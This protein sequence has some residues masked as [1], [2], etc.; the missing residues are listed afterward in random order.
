M[1]DSVGKLLERILLERLYEHLA[2][3]GGH[4]PN[5]Y[6]FRRGRSTEDAIGRVLETARWA[7]SGNPR[8]QELCVL[9]TLDV[10][11]AFNMAPWEHIDAA[12][13]GRGV[14]RYLLRILRSYMG[15]RSLITDDQNSIRDVTCGVPQ[16]SVL[17]PTLW[18]V[19]YDGL[20]DMETPERVQLVGFADDLAL[21]AVART[22]PLLESVV[23]PALQSIEEWMEQH[24]LELA[25][26]KTEA[27]MLTWKRAFADP[28]FTVGGHGIEIKR[29]VK[30]LGVVLD[31]HRTYT[32]HLKTAAGKAAKAAL[33]IGRLMPN[34]SLQS[35]QEG[36]ADVCHQ[37]HDILCS[38]GLG[39]KSH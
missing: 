12:L 2:T 19:L 1:L 33:C 4:S 13:R 7:T 26:Q 5:Q 28:V 25:N 17:G 38:T 31:S 9:I 3:P 37:Q 15:D 30:Y 23:N 22:T 21:I 29:S 20:L 8:F 18:N 34:V 6:G 11:N 27:V 32:K 14:P 35:W 36:T 39:G 24:G 16:G 10:K